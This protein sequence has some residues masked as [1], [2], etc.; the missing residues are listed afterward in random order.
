MCGRQEEEG[1]Q[2]IHSVEEGEQ[3]IHTN[4]EEEQ[5]IHGSKPIVTGSSNITIGGTGIDHRK[6]T[7]RKETFV[8]AANRLIADNRLINLKEEM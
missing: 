5:G 7:G 6:E 3:G 1:E 8:E 2:V 4:K